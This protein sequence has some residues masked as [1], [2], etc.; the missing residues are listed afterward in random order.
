MARYWQTLLLSQWK[1]I[2]KYIPIESQ[3]EK[4]Q[5]EYYNAISTCHNQGSSTVFIEFML[6]QIDKLLDL[7]SLQDSDSNQLSEYVKKLL[8]VMQT[9][10]AYTTKR[11]LELLGLKSKETLRKNYLKPAIEA[12]IIRMEIPDKPTSRNQ[13]YILDINNEY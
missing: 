12:S 1:P 3:I 6:M 11:L 2:F 5:E 10:H 9:S 13:R 8:S 7:V 4:F